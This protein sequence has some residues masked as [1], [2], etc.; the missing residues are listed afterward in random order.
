MTVQT[1]QVIS[2]ML[3]DSTGLHYGFDLAQKAAIKPGVLYPILKRLEVAGWAH[4]AWEEQAP[5]DMGRPRRRY[6]TLT[7][8]GTRLGRA[9]VE[10]HIASLRRAPSHRVRSRILKPS[11]ETA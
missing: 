7:E 11:E 3:Q 9:T 4:S 10:E 2:A 5:E 8:K 1:L 6:Y